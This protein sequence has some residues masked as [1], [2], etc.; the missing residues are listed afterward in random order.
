[1]LEITGDDIAA[2]DDDDLRTLVGRLCEAELRHRDLPMSAITWG[3]SQTAKDG[4]L[5]VRVALDAVTS[6]D[7]FIPK[8]VAGFQVKKQDMPR[9]AIIKEMKPK[10]IIRPAILEL[11]K[12]S[13]AYV[14]VSSAGSTS[15]SALKSRKAA[16]VEALRRVRGAAQLTLE[17]Y[18]RGRIATWVRDHAG[19][20]LWVRSRTG[21]SLPGWRPFG[22]WSRVPARAEATYLVDETARI[23]TGDKD[24]GDGFSATDGINR[25]RN[26]LR[27][28]G[29]V[30]RLVGLSG[31]GKTRLAEALFDPAVGT[32]SLDASLAIYTDI[33]EAPMPAPVGLASD[34]IAAR[35]RA[36]LVIDNCAPDLHR[37]L[38]DL[39]RSTGTTL[40]VITIEYDIREDQ[41][42]G[43]EVFKLDTSSPALIE[44]LVSKRFPDLSQVNARTI[45]EFSGGNA[46]VA[47]ALAGT[48]GKNESISRLSDVDLFRRLFQQRHDPD[49]ALL[50][51]AQ[52]CSLVY[53]FDGETTSGYDAELA[54][55]GRL[56]GKSPA[57]VFSAVAELSRRDLLQR[58][59]PWRAVLPH[60]I[61]NRLAATALESI[62]AAVVQARLIDSASERLLRS[63]SRRLGYLDSST[64]AQA[65]VQGWLAS[66]GLLANVAN[67]NEL[68]RAIFGNVAPVIPEATLASLERALD[69]ADD[70]TVLTCAHFVPLVQ[71]LAYEAMLFERS[72]ALL[73]KFARLPHEG[74]ASRSAANPLESLFHIVL[75]GTHAPLESRI[76]VVDGLLRSA[77]STTQGL[78]VGA[79]QALLK[80]NH[81]TGSSNYEFGARSRD[82]GYHPKT[83]QDVRDWFTA[84]LRFAEPLA[85]SDGDLAE[86]V[87]A[88]I[89]Q[90]FRGLW[91]NSGR[92]DDV[93]RLAR[94]IAAKRF[95]REGWIAA[96]QTRIHDGGGLSADSLARLT[97]LEEF[98]RPKDLVNSIRGTVLNSNSGSLDLDDLDSVQDHDYVAA[99]ARSAAL[100]ERLGRDLAVDE[101]A[102]NTLLPELASG[103]GK[104]AGLGRGVALESENPRGIW[105]AMITQL[106]TTPAPTVD[107]LG[108]FIPGV[109]ERDE[110]LADA[111]LDEALI[112]PTLAKWFPILQRSTAIDAKALERLHRALELGTASVLQFINLAWGRTCDNISGPEFNRLVRAIASKADGIAVAVEILS[113]R[114]HSD[115]TA[116]QPS[117]PGA[118]EAGKWVL[119]RYQF[120]RMNGRAVHED[121]ALGV[122]IRSSLVDDDAKPIVRRLCADFLAAIGRYEVYAHDYGDSVSALFEVHPF[123]MLD[124]LF[125][126]DQRS[127]SSSVH[128]LHELAQF[129]VSPMGAVTDDSIIA[130][131]D[132]DPRARY[133]LA[134]AIAVLFKRPSD[135]DP[136]E[137]TALTQ[138]LLSKAPDPGAVLQ[139]IVHRL[140]P[141]SWS[142]SLATALESR[143]QL[144]ER[145][146]LGTTP[147]L[148]AAHREAATRLR[149]RIEVERRRE[150]E[151][152]RSRSGRFE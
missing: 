113:M 39:V 46:R 66:D 79:L 81:F 76:A 92:L 5:D 87:R 132:R 70:S 121:Y 35:M 25:I 144:L 28:P 112:D 50:A 58:R 44:T 125:S 31:V 138:K 148:L 71:S 146:D 147:A 48:V 52:A 99:A 107:F 43:T 24:E 123:E 128:L 72:V 109:Q 7:G 75:S 104:L 135:N 42:E 96:R 69:D 36:I 30:V 91:T 13:G 38:A 60:A 131:C 55:L 88:A 120:H 141:T 22:P 105:N 119:A 98:L 134:A 85:L 124:Q 1:M 65:I 150:L 84:V 149:Q 74:R 86:K 116:K 137:W 118:L 14:I 26:V 62:P 51:I 57:E 34:L 18:D 33:A 15:D 82:Y 111:L 12:A 68:G 90:E 20:I 145:L 45:A 16:M 3:G 152:D 10:G 78:G 126:G 64:E 95:W 56:I 9:A 63:F 67:L 115:R 140:H 19:L 114:F 139:E 23:T 93:D 151:E 77:D 89:G 41:P 117:V 100:V 8:A 29:G 80:T 4:G 53:S 17:F 129:R 6:I 61:A 11:S 133:P 103:T 2:L 49:A 143:L 102:F 37:Q 47:L 110:T 127:Q 27:T 21:R 59:G 94:A 108:G 83:H 142:G 73:V 106:A 122:I 101:P 136:Y 40:S 130:W 54:I 32:N 97:A